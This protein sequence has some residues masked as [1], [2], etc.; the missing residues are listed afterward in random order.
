MNTFKT[1][2]FDNTLHIG[3]FSVGEKTYEI[4]FLEVNDASKTSI[5]LPKDVTPERYSIYE[6]VFDTIDNQRN[7][8][9]FSRENVGFKAISVFRQVIALIFRHYEEHHPEIYCFSAADTKLE[10]IYQKLLSMLVRKY[11]SFTVQRALGDK[12]YVIRT[13]VSL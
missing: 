3:E 5:V 9:N 4:Y 12:D 11:P 6:V 2:H 10:L 13:P 1:L 8:T 7:G